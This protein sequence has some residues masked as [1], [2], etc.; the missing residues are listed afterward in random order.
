MENLCEIT[1]YWPRNFHSY[2]QKLCDRQR[3][4]CFTLFI[5][6]WSLNVQV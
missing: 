6:N 4:F 5:V 3:R 2:S 1:L